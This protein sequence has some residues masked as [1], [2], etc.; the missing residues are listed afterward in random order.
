MSTSITSA[1]YFASMPRLCRRAV[2]GVE[3]RLAAAEI[4]RRRARQLQRAAERRLEAHALLL[5]PGIGAF[6]LADRHACEVLVGLPAGDA[7]QILPVFLLRVGSRSSSRAARYACSGSCAYAAS[8]RRADGSAPP[9][10]R[11]CARRRA[12]R[13]LIAAAS[14]ALPPPMTR[15][16]YAVGHCVTSEA[17]GSR[18]SAIGCNCAV[19]FSLVSIE[20]RSNLPHSRLLSAP[21]C[22]IACCPTAL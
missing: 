15:M 14:A 5:H 13:A 19:P 4:E 18:Q 21:D 7:Q 22:L 8:C 16:S 6:G 11:E 20:H 10:A 1:S 2:V 9:P 17:V 3:Q 12:A